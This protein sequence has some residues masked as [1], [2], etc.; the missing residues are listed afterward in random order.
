MA[1]SRMRHKDMPYAGLRSEG[2]AQGRCGFRTP[3][4]GRALLVTFG[5]PKVTR[6]RGRNPAL[7]NGAVRGAEAAFQMRKRPMAATFL[8]TGFP[9]SRE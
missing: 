1:S 3:R 9:L 2:R 7:L 6:L 8:R 4:S 5:A